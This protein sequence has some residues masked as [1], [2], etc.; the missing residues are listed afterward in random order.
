MSGI[1]DG[2]RRGMDLRRL[3]APGVLC[4]VVGALLGGLAGCGSGAEAIGKAGAED[5]HRQVDAVRVEFEAGREPA[6]L[7]ALADLRATINRLAAAGELHS[8]DGLVL[9]EQADRIADGIEARATASPTPT[10]TTPTRTPAPTPVV[11]VERPA[12]GDEVGGGAEKTK[13]NGKAKAKG[14]KKGK[15]NG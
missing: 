11:I 6:A 15:G 9:L 13:G 8:A 10:R 1:G 12:G 3:A 2:Y 14:T 4:V 5:L 7:S